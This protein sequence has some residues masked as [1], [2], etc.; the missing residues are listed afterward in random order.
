MHALYC[1]VIGCNSVYGFFIGMFRRVIEN[2]H[3]KEK[4]NGC[5]QRKLLYWWGE[6]TQWKI[7][8]RWC[9]VRYVCNIDCERAN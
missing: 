6:A 5:V 1:S 9:S 7:G 4:M 3:V 2:L 8:V